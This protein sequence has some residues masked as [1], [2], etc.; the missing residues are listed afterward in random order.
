MDTKQDLLHCAACNYQSNA[1]KWD[2]L[3]RPDSPTH[4]ALVPNTPPNYSLEFEGP[5][6]R[7]VKVVCCPRCMA[8]KAMPIIV[9]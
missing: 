5:E 6:L 3:V 8:L 7:A 2:V 4:F 9:E 1:D